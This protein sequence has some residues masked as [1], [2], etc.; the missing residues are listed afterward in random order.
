MSRRFGTPSRAPE[1]PLRVALFASGF[2]A[3]STL[4]TLR[5]RRHCPEVIYTRPPTPIA[6]GLS[7]RRC[8]IHQEADLHR[9]PVRAPDDLNDPSVQAEFAAL[10]LD[11]ALVVDYEQ[12]LPRPM[13]EAPRLGCLAL[14]FSLLPRWRGVA[15]DAWATL[16][17]DEDRGMTVIQMDEGLLTGPVL[18]Q[19]RLDHRDRQWLPWISLT[20]AAGHILLNT[21][22]DLSRGEI[23]PVPQAPE[24][25]TRAPRPTPADRNVDW[26][27]ALYIV[28]QDAA[29]RRHGYIRCRLGKRRI[30]MVNLRHAPGNDGP[31]GTVLDH[32]ITVACARNGGVQVGMLRMGNQKLMDAPDFVRAYGIVPGTV[33]SPG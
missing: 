13:L 6:G 31:P 27:D 21:L 17:G 25:V 12:R 24:L 32:T 28:R 1:K 14:H 22:G 7:Q 33:L 5:M 4:E 10:D 11:A 26:Q 20:P 23:E 16:A 3:V 2:G 19:E 8:V 30:R 15:P 9:I 29:F 18:A